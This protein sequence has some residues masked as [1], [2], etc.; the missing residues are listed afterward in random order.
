MR[1][2]TLDSHL[3]ISP[4]TPHQSYNCSTPI[5]LYNLQNSVSPVQETCWED[6]DVNR[7]GAVQQLEDL[8][9]IFRRLKESNIKIAVY[10]PVPRRSALKTLRHLNL[11]ATVDTVA[12]TDEPGVARR[13][14]WHKIHRYRVI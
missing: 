2:Y 5:Y 7:P 12:C 13:I 1:N 6:C 8:G 9:D 14:S 11:A 10:S 3:S 4:S